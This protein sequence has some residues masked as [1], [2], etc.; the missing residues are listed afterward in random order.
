MKTRIFAV[1]MLSIAG[2]SHAEVPAG[3]DA[4]NGAFVRMLQHEQSAAA[5]LG[6]AGAA[7]GDVDF[8]RWVNTAARFEMSGPE[9]GFAHLLARAEQAP[10]PMQVRGERDPLEVMINAA[11]QAQQVEAHRYASL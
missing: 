3:T 1:A 9:A 8:E 11:L 5:P 4:I 6:S 2:A 10:I 7:A